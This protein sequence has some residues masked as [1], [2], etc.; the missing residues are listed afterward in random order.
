MQ[1]LSLEMIRL[2]LILGKVSTVI[3]N[4][5]VILKKYNLNMKKNETLPIYIHV[6]LGFSIVSKSKVMQGCD[7]A[8][9]TFNCQV[10]PPNQ[11]FY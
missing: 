3:F 4:N 11:L 6:C 10:F 9:I 7:R 1:D 5:S 2:R 8:K